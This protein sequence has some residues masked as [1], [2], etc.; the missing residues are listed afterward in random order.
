MFYSGDVYSD[1]NSSSLSLEG[2]ADETGNYTCHWNNSLRQARFK[3]FTVT[4]VDNSE[5]VSPET[6]AISV[7][8][9]ILLLISIIVSVKFYLFKVSVKLTAIKAN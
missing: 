5:P 3:N 8:F 6:I 2:T 7:S 9:A 4:Y 1:T